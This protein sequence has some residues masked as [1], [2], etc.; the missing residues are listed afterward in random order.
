MVDILLYMHSNVLK[1]TSECGHACVSKKVLKMLESDGVEAV[2]R[3]MFYLP[4]VIV[5]ICNL[6]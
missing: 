6:H 4:N 5:Q 1:I 2:Y 3:L